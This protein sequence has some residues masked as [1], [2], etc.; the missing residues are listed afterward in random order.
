MTVKIRNAAF[1][2]IFA[3][4]TLAYTVHSEV[5]ARTWTLSELDTLSSREWLWIDKKY[6]E[7][8]S[9]YYTETD[10]PDKLPVR[11]RYIAPKYPKEASKA[12]AE[13]SVWV[14]ILID[15]K[16]KVRA[17]RILEDSGTDVGF[18]DA[19]LAA[20]IKSKWKPAIKNG[21]PISIWVSFESAF[22]LNITD[23]G[24]PVRQIDQWNWSAIPPEVPLYL[25]SNWQK[26]V[27]D[28]FPGLDEFVGIEKAPEMVKPKL[29]KYPESARKRGLQGS[30]WVKVLVDRSGNVAQATVA[31]ESG[32]DCGFEESA[33][34]AAINTKWKP[35]MQDNQPIALWITYEITFVLRH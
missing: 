35:A 19:A 21:N 2:L 4:A 34:W 8:I 30:V 7:P 14:K 27:T 33:L 9:E 32:C 17:A 18:E 10:A 25:G 11:S 24:Q 20:A 16:G 5:A 15:E 13:G 28:D 31:K 26:Q 22:Y 12:G 29:I 23:D 3:Y 6:N 1:M